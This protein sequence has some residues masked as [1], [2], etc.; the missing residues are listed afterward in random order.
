MTTLLTLAAVASTAT[1]V[2][3]VAVV[4]YPPRRR[5]AARVRPYAAGA[6]SRLGRPV[7]FV[8][9]VVTAPDRAVWARVRR[10]LVGLLHGGTA[11]PLV[12]SMLSQSG[13]YQ[14]AP[15]HLLGEHRVRQMFAGLIGGALALGGAV[16]VGLAPVASLGSAVVGVTAGALRPAAQVDRAINQRRRTLR[17]EIP[18]L[19]QLLA[20]RL[21]ANGSVVAALSQTLERTEGLLVDELAE[22]LAQHRA[23]GP[24]DQSLDAAAT[25]TAEPEAARVHRLLAGAIRHGLDVAPELL[26]V[27]RDARLTHLAGLR[28]D[29]TRRRAAILL[30]TVGLLAPLILLF[31]AA[32]LPG[33]ILG[34]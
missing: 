19:C 24:L 20:L 28:R 23:G 31:I 1:F 2:V 14:A 16:L 33:M 30:P 32:P 34:G 5:L 3:T 6:L 11:D 26:R 7:V 9:V 17:A 10:R 15:Q 13:L 21:R 8:P 25:M 22:A 29:A 12:L 4:V 27:A 18:P